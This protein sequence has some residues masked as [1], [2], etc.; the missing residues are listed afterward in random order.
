MSAPPSVASWRI[1]ELVD[2]A[3]R[4]L[5][6]VHVAAAALI[7]VLTSALL[8]AGAAELTT[9]FAL[10]E[11]R[12]AAG[13]DVVVV[14]VPDDE[15][16]DAGTCGRLAASG[17]VL[18]AGAN[19]GES[20]HLDAR[21]QPAG[22][23]VPLMDLTLGALR[24]WWPEA[25]AGGGLF[26][27]ADLRDTTGLDAGMTV[28]ADGTPLTVTGVLPDS[29]TPDLW[30]A[31]V[32]RLVPAAGPAAECWIRMAAGTDASGG[33][34]AAAFP[35]NRP[36]V[37][38]FARHDDLSADPRVFLESSPARFGWLAG[39]GA[40]LVVLSLIALGRRE[41]SGIYRVTGTSW[42]ELAAMALVQTVI[43]VLPAAALATAATMLAVAWTTDLALTGDVVWYLVQPV[44]LM[45][46]ALCA[47][48]PLGH[49]A[50]AAGA[51][52]DT[53]RT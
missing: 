48:A 16:L 42:P 11:A 22:V 4:R 38:P 31:S 10:T 35:D 12:A 36:I 15:T 1:G 21:W 5:T 33:H 24:T 45:V 13:V 17:A 34:V 3:W 37:V 47:V 20:V 9:A 18:A 43:L 50:A 27:G 40:G 23:A 6:P 49:V 53:M 28:T 7:G 8:V 41:E 30:Q 19:F 51:Q 14:S 2:E 26:V 32:V 39:T 44:V 52:V 46:L 29:V 25:P